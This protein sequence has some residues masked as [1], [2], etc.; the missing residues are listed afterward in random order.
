MNPFSKYRSVSHWFSYN[1]GWLLAILAIILI[2]VFLHFTSPKEVDNSDYTITWVGNSQLSQ[3]EENA[4]SDAVKKCG[5][6]LNGDG[7]IITKV[8]QYVINYNPDKSDSNIQLYYTNAMKLLAEIQV[9]SSYIY[10]LDDPEGFQK[11]TGILADSNG[12]LQS[13]KP[14]NNSKNWQDMCKLWS[15][16]DF[17]RTAYIARRGMFDNEKSSN[18]T[19]KNDQKLYDALLSINSAK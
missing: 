3:T 4:I 5:N 1:W 14:D 19:L 6:D 2:G 16:S 7:K 10:L 12:N 13:D 8:D 9:D 17:K 18:Q 15:Y 11:S